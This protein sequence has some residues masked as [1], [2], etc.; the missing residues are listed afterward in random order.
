M[1]LGRRYAAPISSTLGSP[2]VSALDAQATG[3]TKVSRLNNFKQHY[4]PL[5][6]SWVLYDNAGDQPELL[7]WSEKHEQFPVRH[8]EKSRFT[9]VV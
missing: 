6:N 9:S 3:S 8:C 1:G 2:Y 5:V 7:D 4:T